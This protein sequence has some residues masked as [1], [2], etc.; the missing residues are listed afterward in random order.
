MLQASTGGLGIC[1]LKIKGY[2]CISNWGKIFGVE[3]FILFTGLF[4]T[5]GARNFWELCVGLTGDSV[6]SPRFGLNAQLGAPKGV[7]EAKERMQCECPMSHSQG[8]VIGSQEE[9]KSK[10]LFNTST[11]APN[12]F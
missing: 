7:P 5:L 11:P 12:H 8:C 6:W 9:S 10:F 3:Y 2:Y 1:L 4:L